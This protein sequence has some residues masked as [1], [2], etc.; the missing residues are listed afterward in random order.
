[1]KNYARLLFHHFLRIEQ[2]G[3]LLEAAMPLLKELTSV[4][5][6]IPS[7]KPLKTIVCN[8]TGESHYRYTGSLGNDPLISG[9]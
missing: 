1:M 5:G 7:I 9:D 2:V 6:E 8:W 4:D 3:S